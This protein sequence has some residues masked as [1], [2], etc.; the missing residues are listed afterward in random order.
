MKTLTGQRGFTLLEVLIAVVILSIGLL[1][2]A[3]LMMTSVQASQGAYLRGQASLLAYDFSERT[4]LNH[5]LA[6]SADDYLLDADSQLEV[7]YSLGER[8]ECGDDGCTDT[9]QAQLDLH[10]WQTMLASSIPGA[11]ANITRTDNQYSIEIIWVESS[12]LEGVTG[13]SSFAVSFDL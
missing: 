5:A 6:S 8:P 2:M 13:D 12:A 9:E 10:Q 3:T 1:G 4:R 11:R 7:D